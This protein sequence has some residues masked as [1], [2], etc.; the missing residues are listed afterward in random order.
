MIV[1]VGSPKN[2]WTWPKVSSTWPK[3]FYNSFLARSSS[4][5][6]RGERGDSCLLSD[7]GFS[8]VSLRSVAA[9]M[10]VCQHVLAMLV[11]ASIYSREIW[12]TKAI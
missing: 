7:D 8:N 5:E 11:F 2:Y 6:P 1:V 10:I 12:M 9:Q 3:Q 4:P